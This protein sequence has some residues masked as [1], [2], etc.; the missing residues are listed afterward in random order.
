MQLISNYSKSKKCISK[1]I[2]VHIH[3]VLV[4][5]DIQLFVKL[6]TVAGNANVRFAQ[7][8]KIAQN[9]RK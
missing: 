4:F 6:S 5:S 7:V 1:N 3:L 2:I 8:A 9:H